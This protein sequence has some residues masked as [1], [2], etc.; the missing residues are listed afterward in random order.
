MAR[1]KGNSLNKLLNNQILF[2]VVLLICILNLIGY[3]GRRKWDSVFFFLLVAIITYY[4]SR[5]PTVILLISLLATNF[6]RTSN[7]MQPRME[8][9]G[10]RREGLV[11]KEEV[12]EDEE[13]VLDGG[14]LSTNLLS[15]PVGSLGGTLEGLDAQLGDAKAQQ[16][17]MVQLLKKMEPLVN[18]SMKMLENLPVGTIE[19]LSER[20]NQ[21]KT[22]AAATTA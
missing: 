4:F 1:R 17:S 9:M 14:K 15:A 10:S 22:A 7:R 13:E 19:K 3:I 2:L 11:E 8:G 20:L 5:N 16:Q 18:E 21:T 12:D 6:Y